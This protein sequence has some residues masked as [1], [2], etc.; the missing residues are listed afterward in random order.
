MLVLQEMQ[1]R[2]FNWLEKSPY[3]DDVLRKIHLS[4]QRRLQLLPNT[5]VAGAGPC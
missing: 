3:K 4:P 5:E 1:Y 2:L